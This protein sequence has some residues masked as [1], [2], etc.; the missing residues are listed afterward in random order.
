MLQK[1]SGKDTPETFMEVRTA[2]A[3]TGKFQKFP[4]KG[5]KKHPKGWLWL[6]HA[7]QHG[8]LLCSMLISKRL[9]VTCLPK[10]ELALDMELHFGT[11]RNFHRQVNR[12]H[13][14]QDVSK[15]CR[16]GVL[17][18]TR[19][20]H[21]CFAFRLSGLAKDLKW[22]NGRTAIMSLLH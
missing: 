10:V 6:A 21:Q 19:N 22:L 14:Q 12:F 9:P 11:I 16:L 17:L 5:S 3:G 7:K 13:Q 4:R 18:A 1:L 15:P 8:T 20:S 2:K